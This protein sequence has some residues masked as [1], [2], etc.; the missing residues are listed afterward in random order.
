MANGTEPKWWESSRL[1]LALLVLGAG[2][3]VGAFLIGSMW[4][5]I[6][7]SI[8]PELKLPLVVIFGVVILL[9]VIALVTFSFSQLNLASREQALG[10]PDGSVRAIIALMLLVLFSIVAIFLY[11]SV[12]ASGALQSVQNVTAPQLEIMRKQVIVVLT[13]AD[14]GKETAGPFTVYFRNSN[15]AGEDIARQLITLLGTLVTAVASF[16]FGA[17][18][19]SSA[20]DAVT[21]AP[22][23]SGGGPNATDVSPASLNPGG[24]PQQLTISGANLGKVNTAK[25]VSGDG[26]T[27]I[28]ADAGSLKASATSVTC[29]VTVPPTAAPGAY[30]VVLW[31]NANNSSTVPK[32]V[33]INPGQP[34]VPAVNKPAPTTIDLTDIKANGSAQTLTIAG[35]NLENVIRVEL[36]SADGK[37]TIPTT[38]VAATAAKVAFSVTVS[39]KALAGQYNV[40]VSDKANNVV[41]IPQKVTITA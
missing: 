34:A 15:P 41:T 2:V 27:S 25:L 16:Y 22:G 9:I 11:N 32:G 33:T 6:G 7:K 10:L 38:G 31:D 40:S 12:A 5:F 14:A 35:T 26:K 30:D 13:L 17:T 19:V 18:S 36:K 8:G 1:T 39:D 24:P 23:G 20:H 21:K 4:L 29:S 3:L 37:T 28:P